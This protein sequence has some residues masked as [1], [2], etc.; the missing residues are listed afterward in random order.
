[1][2]AN[3][4]VESRIERTPRVEQVAGLFDLAHET[5]SK[6][7]WS[8][9][10]PIEERPWN[11]G[12]ITGPSGCG[13]STIARRLFPE[14]HPSP[15]LWLTSLPN[16][17]SQ[18]AVVDGFPESMSIKDVTALL[19]SVGF[20]SPPAWL[21]PYHVLSTG[22]RFR[23]DLARMLAS[24]D[25]KKV[26]VFDEYTSVVDRTVA[27]IGSAAVAR[28]IRQRNLKFIAVSCHDDI[29]EWLQPDWVY[30]PAE[31]AFRWRSL[32]RRPN[33]EMEITRCTASSWQLFAP[34]HY[35]SG[36]LVRSAWCFLALHRGRPVCFSSWLP[37][38]GSGPLARREHRTVVLPDFQGVGIGMRISTLIASMWA[39]L[40]YVAR[41]T[42]THPA[43]AQARLR[44]P[45][46]ALVRQPSLAQ[47]QEKKQFRR[48]K[49][50]TTR[51]TSGW[52]F[53]GKP[54]ERRVAEQLLG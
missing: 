45:D 43:F 41:S 11:I 20:S 54:M 6:L 31:E 29:M 21:R 14:N 38:V 2:K 8:V 9:E 51:L 4:T 24:L 1:M 30:L 10:L 39:G 50:A 35:L 42:T 26:G 13:K 15:Y 23:C 5:T 47:G 46:W 25:E 18:E 44:S 53:V 16:W 36:D 40:G 3:I 33:I 19:S 52:R 27:Q 22:Q 34:H 32:Q 37:F 49:R 7:S 17:S 48:L 28:T 12:L